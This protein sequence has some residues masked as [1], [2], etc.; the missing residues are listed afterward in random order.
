MS[1]EPKQTTLDAALRLCDTSI[2]ALMECE[3][4]YSYLLS[5]FKLKDDD[6]V[7]AM[8]RTAPVALKPV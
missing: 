8:A 4:K 2:A 5:R 1:V 3:N 6:V 7:R